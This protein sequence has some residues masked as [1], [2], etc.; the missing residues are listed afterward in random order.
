ME[1]EIKIYKPNSRHGLGFFQAWII[2]IKNIFISRE[3]IFQIMKRDFL[4]VYKKT[5]LGVAW[6]VITPI[7]GILSWVFMQMTGILR[8]GETGIP[9]PAY[10][11]I[12]SSIWG[13]FAGLVNS[14]AQ[15]LK[16]GA[17][18]IMQVD[19]PHEALLVQQAAQQ[20]A[21]FIISFIVIIIVLSIF[22]IFPSWKIVFL[23]FVIIPVFFL[24]SSIG[25]I[26]S[27][28]SVITIE[29]NGVINGS[30]GLLFFLTPIVYSNEVD[31][32][33]V[34]LIIKW[35]PLTYI[36]CSVRDMI[37]Y[38]RLYDTNGYIISSVLS[39]ILFLFSWR[40]FFISEK[41]LVERM[42]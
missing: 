7:F 12:G 31:S 6:I 38:G 9:Y 23:P 3:F 14:S 35:N 28:I 1:K 42:I 13:L 29:I 4:A 30:L 39:V 34:K 17:E 15:T 36:V 40:L 18:L 22:R 11:M 16:A 8:P 10:V 5:F 19:Y 20:L 25:L 21:T 33:V 27:M 41:T 32:Q 26:C 24:A 2:M 37:I